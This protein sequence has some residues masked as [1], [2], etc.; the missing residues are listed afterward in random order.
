MVCQCYWQSFSSSLHYF[1]FISP[2]VSVVAWFSSSE[3]SQLFFYFTGIFRHWC[4][5]DELNNYTEHRKLRAV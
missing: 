3:A 4:V 2:T 5:S 1:C